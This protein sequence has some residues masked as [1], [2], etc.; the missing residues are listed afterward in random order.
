MRLSL[1]KRVFLLIAAINVAVFTVGGWFAADRLDAEE[2]RLASRFDASLAPFLRRSILPKGDPNIARILQWPGWDVVQ[3]A[4]LREGRMRMLPGGGVIWQGVRLNPVGASS[5]PASFRADEV[6]AAL[7]EAIATGRAV[8]GAQGGVAIPIEGPNGIWGGCWYRT[9]SPF[10]GTGLLTTFLWGYVASTLLLTAG[11]FYFLRRV[12]LDPVE[13]LAEGARNVRGGDLSFRLEEPDRTDELADL[14]RSFNL[15]TSTVQGFNERLADEV[16]RATLQARR[17]EGAAMTQR[18]LAAMGEL[19]AGIAHEINNPLGGLQ[20]A[21]EQLER[22][23]LQPE[24]R[25]RYLKL[26]ADGLERIRNTVGQLLRFTP[27]ET[28]TAGVDLG[29]VALDAMALVRHRAEK[30]GVEMELRV[31]DGPPVEPGAPPPTGIP[32]IEGSRHDLGQALLNLLVNALDAL[33]EGVPGREPGE[34]R[35]ELRLERRPE[36]LR[37]IVQDDGPGAAP[38]V[39]ERAADLFYSTKEVGKGTGLGLSIV[40]NVL[41]NHGG[42][43]ELSSPPGGGFRVEL[44]LPLP[45]STNG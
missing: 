11:T 20:N 5:R 7:L 17:A 3:D 31:D 18:R 37:L 29:E 32:R 25:E 10:E 1:R 41:A 16:E 21:V 26:L 40:H 42:S 39:L 15:M 24:R 43:V 33:A 2:D 28:V 19:A 38:E 34:G 4:V 9:A 36:V 6:E 22:E 23:D 14:V 35:I 44:E 8:T 45:G 12:V 27:R 13:K 30:Q